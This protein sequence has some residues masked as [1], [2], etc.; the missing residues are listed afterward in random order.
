MAVITVGRYLDQTTDSVKVEQGDPG[1]SAWLV[2]DLN[3][4]VPVEYDY[5]S[6]TYVG[7]TDNV[8]TVTY[9][10]GGSGGATVAVLTLT[11]DGSSRITSVT[12]A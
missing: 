7:A 8:A 4:L 9:K 10:T 12:R 11:Y 1:P 3:K 2:R 6:L 5:I